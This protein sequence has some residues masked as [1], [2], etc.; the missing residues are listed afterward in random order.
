MPLHRN[1]RLRLAVLGA[2]IALVPGIVACGGSDDDGDTVVQRPD[3]AERQPGGSPTVTD[4]G[5][6]GTESSR[7][8]KRSEAEKGPRGDGGGSNAK[9]AEDRPAAGSDDTDR[10]AVVV[11]EM[12]DDMARADA[13]GVCA[14]MS[15]AVRRQ[16]AQQVLGGSATPSGE[17][18][19]E[20]S[21]TRFLDAA[22]GSETLQ[23]VPRATVQDVSIRG[24]RATAT[25]SFG[26]RSGKVGLVR[27]EGDW[28]FD[29]APTAR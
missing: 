24:D 12:Y 17:R 29:A 2:L 13:A 26:K 15:R 9:P 14:A 10:V 4:D 3:S 7:D 16:T 18:T 1:D 21:L 23:D 8:D 20:A 28:R 27:E 6:Q 19:C 5:P 11:T 25:V 22:A